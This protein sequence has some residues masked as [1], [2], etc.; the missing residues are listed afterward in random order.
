[1]KKTQDSAQQAVPRKADHRIKIVFLVLLGAL[2]VLIYWRQLNPKLP[3]WGDDLQET[4]GEARREG[5]K[6]VVLFTAR[7][8]G[9][10]ARRLM[11][12]TL[13]KTANRQAIEE[14]N[15]IHIRLKL[16]TSL[17]EQIAKQYKIKNLPTMLVL[18]S[19]GRE[20]NRREGMIGEMAFRKGF[21][22]CAKIAKP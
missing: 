22:D 16:D 11:K 17:T 2:G 4:L 20:L 5:R 21:L 13:G 18:S 15:F 7:H 8:P 10:I 6:V 14:G 9:E 3:G 19:G 1:M 12:T